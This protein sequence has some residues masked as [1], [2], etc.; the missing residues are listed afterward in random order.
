VDNP[1]QLLDS[2]IKPPAPTWGGK[3]HGAGAPP[4]NLNALKNGH[5]SPRLLAY[6]RA[7]A[8]DPVMQNVIVEL[9][10][11]DA[12]GGDISGLIRHALKGVPIAS[13][14]R[15]YTRRNLRRLRNNRARRIERLVMALPVNVWILHPPSL[16][17]DAEGRPL[18]SLRKTDGAPYNPLTNRFE[19]IKPGVPQTISAAHRRVQRALLRRYYEDLLQWCKDEYTARTV[20]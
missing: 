16:E 8:N 14:T 1:L 11:V 15:E 2:S 9:V 18:L 19:P 20:E 5:R 3:R 17:R 12:A 10:R 4:G 13:E 7:L 6:V